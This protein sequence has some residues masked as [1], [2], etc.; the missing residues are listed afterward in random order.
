MGSIGPAA[1]S[2]VPALE[3][4]ADSSDLLLRTIS[5]W[6]LAKIERG[7]EARRLDAVSLLAAALGS[8]QPQV[9]RAARRGLADLKPAPAL[10][11]PAIKNALAN[12]DTAV[13]TNAVEALG[14]LGEPAVPALIDALKIERFVPLW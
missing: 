14:S 5:T 11:L 12:R 1:K 7:N 6:A 9:R 8:R 10:V 13:A 4:N 3:M 2:A